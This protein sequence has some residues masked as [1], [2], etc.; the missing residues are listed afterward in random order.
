[1]SCSKKENIMTYKSIILDES[2]LDIDS[3]LPEKAIDEIVEIIKTDLE[4]QSTGMLDK[5]EKVF[6]NDIDEMNDK[7]FEESL[8]ELRDILCDERIAEYCI[9]NDIAWSDSAMTGSPIEVLGLAKELIQ[10]G[11]CTGGRKND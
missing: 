4:M 11:F 2:I 5:N 8:L 7:E 9:E 6:E 1:M 10:F 3:W